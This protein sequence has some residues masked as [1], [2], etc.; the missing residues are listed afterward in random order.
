MK[1]K[2]LGLGKTFI[3]VS[4]GE[5]YIKGAGVDTQ[6]ALG[7]IKKAFLQK[8]VNLQLAFLL[9]IVQYQFSHSNC[10]TSNFNVIA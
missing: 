7:M 8:K 3:N 1:N 4:G 6:K 10:T 2:C 9:N 5:D